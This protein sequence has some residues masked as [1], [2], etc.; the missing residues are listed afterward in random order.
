MQ[1]YF[2]YDQDPYGYYRQNQ[3]LIQDIGK[4][5][6]DEFNAIHYYTKLA[7]LTTNTEF[8]NLILRVRQDE[9]KHFHRFAKIY[10]DLTK[11]YPHITLNHTLPTSFKQ[12]IRESIRDEQETVPFYRS[13]AARLSNQ[14]HKNTVMQAAN[15]EA[16]HFKVFSNINSYLR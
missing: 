4:A 12:G 13:I 8:R 14:K 16:R 15:D 3:K 10:T 7:E 6:Q 11:K 9:I 2:Y 5:V 1:E